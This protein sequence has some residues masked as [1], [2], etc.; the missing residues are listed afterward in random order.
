MKAIYKLVIITLLSS[1]A[2][3]TFADTLYDKRFKRWQSEAEKGNARAQY[4]LGNA[5][6]RGNEVKIDINEAIKW[7]EA[8]AKQGHSKSEY[9]LGYIYYT[10][11]F[12]SSYIFESLSKFSLMV[13]DK[14]YNLLK[15]F[16][17]FSTILAT[18]QMSLKLSASLRH[19][20]Q[21]A[22]YMRC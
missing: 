7:F 13:P 9:K 14:F 21:I 10:F 6:L 11:A 12:S 5:Y 3:S 4:S 22:K 2:Y 19:I 1:L 20:F 18:K 16:V 8:A 17:H 15:T